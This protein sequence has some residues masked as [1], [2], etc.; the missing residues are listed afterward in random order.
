[1]EASNLDLPA[2]LTQPLTATPGI[3]EKFI[4]AVGPIME[5]RR[6]AQGKRPYAQRLPGICGGIEGQQSLTVLGIA[7]SKHKSVE[8]HF[9]CNYKS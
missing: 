5:C 8:M 2:K 1:M 3:T 7:I 9:C 4:I 6:G